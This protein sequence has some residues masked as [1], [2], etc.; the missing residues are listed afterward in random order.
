ILSYKYFG[1]LGADPARIAS[2]VLAGIGFIGGG[3]ILKENHRVLGLTTAASLW[4]T[5]SVG[6]A[7]GIGAY[8]LAATGT[9]LGL[10]SLLLKNI[11]KRE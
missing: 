3:V 11:E 10:L 2:Y 8:D 9:I 6:M 4:L 7:V 1:A 5:A